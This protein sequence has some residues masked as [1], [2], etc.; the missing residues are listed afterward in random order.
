[1][2]Q[3]GAEDGYANPRHSQQ[4]TRIKLTAQPYRDEIGARR[5]VVPRCFCQPRLIRALRQPRSRMFCHHVRLSQNLR[6]ASPSPLTNPRG[7]RWPGSRR[8]LPGSTLSRSTASRRSWP[9]RSA[10]KPAWPR[11][12]VRS[13]VVAAPHP[14]LTGAA[15][16]PGDII[17]PRSLARD[18]RIVVAAAASRGAR[19]QF[20]LNHRAM[21]IAI[22]P[23]ENRPNR[24][25][26]HVASKSRQA[27]LRLAQT[28]RHEIVEFVRLCSRERQRTNQ[29]IRRPRCFRE[30][31]RHFPSRRSESG[32]SKA[33]FSALH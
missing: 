15:P 20:E 9:G 4:T 8:I 30:R 31:E 19:S 14:R 18:C 17:L 21:S 24:D 2:G 7:G 25:D 23:S 16:K 28:A 12:A 1:M 5:S 27:A 33:H 3:P 13:R 10:T 6:T 26:T 22:A 11:P 32:H 29:T